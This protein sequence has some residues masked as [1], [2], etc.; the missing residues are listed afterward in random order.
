MKKLLS[1]L[2]LFLFAVS[3]VWAE[4]TASEWGSV[5]NLSGRQR[6]LSQKMTKETLLI[7]AG[8]DIEKNKENLK[9]T[10]ELFKTTLAGLRDGNPDMNLPKCEN[11]RIVA[12]LD[13]VKS[14]YDELEPIFL[15]AINGEKL[16]DDELQKLAA[17]NLPLLKEMNKAVKMFERKSKKVLAG[18][19]TE[20]SVVINLAGKQRMLT[21]K[22]SKEALL[23]YLGINKEE[24]VINLRE[25]S[26]L[27]DK[28]L[29]GLK[30]GDADLGLPGTGQADIRAQLDIVNN[31][32][33]EFYPIIKRISDASSDGISEDDMKKIAELNLPLLKE[34]NKAVGMYE[35]LTK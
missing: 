34:M 5:M 14:L 29:K 4:P 32:W 18:A 11:E 30:D 8:I 3:L 22:M 27:F 17:G 20:L 31:L 7:Q 1:V 23:V 25:T 19:G 35:K 10:I 33:Q 9:K 21:Q 13:K 28:T 24:N 15:K 12:Q 6:M 16:S 26:S 2:F